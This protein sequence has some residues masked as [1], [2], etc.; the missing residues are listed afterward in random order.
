MRDADETCHFS[1]RQMASHRR[2]RTQGGAIGVDSFA[3]D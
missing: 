3:T 1:I 2:N